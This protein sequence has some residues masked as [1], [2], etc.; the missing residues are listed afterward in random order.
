M[1]VIPVLALTTLATSANGSFDLKARL[2]SFEEVPPNAT[3]AVGTFEG[4]VR[5]GSTSI[6]DS[7][8]YSGTSTDVLFAHIHF[9]QRGVNGGIMAFLCSNAGGPAGTPPC[10]I[11]AGTVTGTISAGTVIGPTG[12]AV[13]AGDLAAVIEAIR[14]GD[15]YANVHT[16]LF[17][18]GELRGQ[19]K[20]D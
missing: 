5:D 11:R 12:Q 7:L 15:V 19:V 10:P 17:P 8:T 14:V 3:G 13:H 4:K 16:T 1:A 9:A 18:G 20:D 6:T 2:T